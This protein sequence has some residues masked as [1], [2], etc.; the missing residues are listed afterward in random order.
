MF[1]AKGRQKS[2][3]NFGKASA[4]GPL[5]PASLPVLLLFSRLIFSVMLFAFCLILMD[6]S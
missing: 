2:L 1:S 3:K 5:E 4:F 6:E